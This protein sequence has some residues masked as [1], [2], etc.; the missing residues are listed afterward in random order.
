MSNTPEDNFNSQVWEILQDIKE[1]YLVTENLSDVKYHMPNVI[2]YGIIPPDRRKN[3]LYKLKDWGAVKI[4][5][6]DAYGFLISIND[7]KFDEIYEKYKEK[8]TNKQKSEQALRPISYKPS[9]NAQP[10]TVAVNPNVKIAHDFTQGKNAWF[11]DRL[12]QVVYWLR[13]E[14][15]LIGRDHFKIPID[16]Y[17]RQKIDLDE[18]KKILIHL[19]DKEIVSVFNKLASTA[20]SDNPFMPTLSVGVNLSSDETI[21]SD[22]KTEITLQHPFKYLYEILE[23]R[24]D[25]DIHRG[26][27]P[28]GLNQVAESI[29]YQFS[30]HNLPF[31]YLVLTKIADSIEFTSEDEPAHY[32]LQSPPGDQ[33]ILE[34]KL[35]TK[36][37]SLGLFKI[38]E[39]DGIHG[40]SPISNWN[41]LLIRKCLD[42]ISG[43]LNQSTS[44]TESEIEKIDDIPVPIVDSGLNQ[45]NIIVTFD[46]QKPALL[47][48]VKEVAIP[49]QTNQYFLCETLFGSKKMRWENDELLEKFGSDAETTEVKRQPYDAYL[50]VNKKVKRETGIN[51]L[52]LYEAKTYRINPKYR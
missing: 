14:Q 27:D 24:N 18:V 48:G 9:K 47:V 15:L 21:F 35:L 16:R 38:G 44:K 30:S 34:R 1:E 12:W 32:Q 23:V 52:I 29:V 25:P 22:P 13:Q 7:E 8:D 39:E 51:D 2:G 19:E 33:I 3:I 31:V 45:S 43:K 28:S 11:L 10:G 50:A 17:R 49:Y 41:L 26:E 42:R 6:Q 40:I 36:L 37:D 5:G 46:K 4:K 20:K